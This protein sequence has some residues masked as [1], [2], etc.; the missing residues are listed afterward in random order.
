MQIAS[1]LFEYTWTLWK[2]DVQTILQNFSA[3]LQ[4]INVNSSMEQQNDLLLMCERW[5]LCLKIIRQLIISGHPSDTTSAQ[6]SCQ[7]PVKIL[8]IFCAISFRDFRR[9]RQVRP[10]KFK[11]TLL[12]S[13]STQRETN[14]KL[15]RPHKTGWCAASVKR[16][17]CVGGNRTFLLPTKNDIAI[18]CIHF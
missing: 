11:M 17:Q 16:A 7:V 3:L 14:S 13:R 1:H 10:I 12:H 18:C 4:C 8:L 9:I 15:F 2:S 6:V 5:L